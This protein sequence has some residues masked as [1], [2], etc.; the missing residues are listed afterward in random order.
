MLKKSRIYYAVIF[1]IIILLVMLFFKY[2][3]P[4]EKFEGTTPNVVD[5]FNIPNM[6]KWKFD[7]TDTTQKWDKWYP[8]RQNGFQ[9][10]FKD[11]GLTT[12]NSRMSIVF[13]FHCKAGAN[14]WRN[15]FHFTNTGNNCC[16]KG[17]RIPA[18][19]V[20]PDGTNR[21]HIRFSTDSNG[22]DGSDYTINRPMN[23]PELVS[24]VF[25]DNRYT[26]YIND[27]KIHSGTYNNIVK[28]EQNAIFYIGDPW[29]YSDNNILIKN[30]TLYNGVLTEQN[31]KDIYNGVDKESPD[32]GPTGP[33][34]IPGATGPRG[35]I[36]NF[37]LLNDSAWLA[38]INQ[39]TP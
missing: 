1:L 35:P 7:N 29:H 14:Q 39:P 5:A 6:N 26:L 25:D 38:K 15:I 37:L 11:L 32:R 20:Y 27:V 3:V 13:M 18:M 24:M 21:F 22:N 31:V 23:T 17:D 34:G 12:P 33:Q 19:W 16:S 36:S 30:F 9:K 2:N 28:R 10:S 4:V 8:V